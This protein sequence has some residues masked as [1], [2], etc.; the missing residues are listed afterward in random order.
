[1]VEPQENE[2]KKE[3]PSAKSIVSSIFEGGKE[4]V[5]KKSEESSLFRSSPT[6]IEPPQGPTQNAKT[7]LASLKTQAQTWI[8]QAKGLVAKSISIPRKHEPIHVAYGEWMDRIEMP[9]GLEIGAT[10]VRAVQLYQNSEHWH[11]VNYA[12]KP[13]PLETGSSSES[14]QVVQ[15]TL[16][17]IF[18]KKMENLTVVS[19]FPGSTAVARVFRMPVMSHSELKQA[20]TW[21]LQEQLAVRVDDW[22]FDFAP[23]QAASVGEGK[24]RLV[25][26]SAVSKQ[27]LNTH[28][29]MLKSMGLLPIAV[30][31][32]P[33]PTWELLADHPWPVNEAA[34]LIE[35]GAQISHVV[36]VVKGAPALVH[37]LDFNGEMLS[38]V[39]QRM[40]HFSRD[41][42]ESFKSNIGLTQAELQ[43]TTQTVSSENTTQ[44]NYQAYLALRPFVD[45]MINEIDQAFKYVSFRVFQSSVRS[46]SRVF[47]SGKAS[48]LKGLRELL[49]E[50]LGVPVEYIQPLEG[51][52]IDEKVFNQETLQKEALGLA[53]AIGL[54]ERREN[55]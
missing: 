15:N 26:V 18:P 7:K 55:F 38:K 42:A 41:E 25:L 40:L 19:S 23:I 39:I 24:E 11:L 27:E 54:A 9:V 43:T 53:T 4:E 28:V 6:P 13:L 14:A 50:R 8:D 37:P 31:A 17:E 33:L 35:L 29:A 3:R 44:K 49:E 1:M 10:A 51:I 46:F 12:V 36:I 32:K 16:R 2:K 22:Y 48:L 52:L 47:L 5:Q 45:R 30:E 34:L 20:V 21:E